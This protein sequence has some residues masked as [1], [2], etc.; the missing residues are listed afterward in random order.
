MRER[1]L[2]FEPPLGEHSPHPE[3]FAFNWTLLQYVFPE[4][5]DPRAFP[6][7]PP[8]LEHDEAD[9]AMYRRYF[10]AAEELAESDVICGGDTMAVRIDDDTGAEHVS[11][12]TT[13]T[14]E[15][16]RGFSVLLRQF[17]A[18]EEEASFQRVSGR[19]RKACSEAGDGVTTRTEQ[20]DHW[21]HAQGKL[22]AVELVRLAR[23]KYSPHMEFGNRHSPTYYFSA[24]NYGHLIHWD[25]KRDVIATWEADPYFKHGERLAFL[26]AAVG[27]AH[28]YIGF[29]LVVSA[30][31]GASAASPR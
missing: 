6:P 30:A 27:I 13:S 16:V 17:D 9:L 28:L 2:Q 25:S 4:I 5:N 29:S 23:R 7:L 3:T 31:L 21:R 11:A 14:R 1:S 24:Y 18:K 10:V 26:N 19:L 8:A 15:A 22:H 12:T 20:I